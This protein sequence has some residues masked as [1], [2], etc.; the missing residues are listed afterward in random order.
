MKGRM[1]SRWVKV[2][3]TKIARMCTYGVPTFVEQMEFAGQVESE[4]P[5][6]S[7]RNCVNGLNMW[8]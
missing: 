6:A 7:E 5:Q 4:E 2:Y 8:S 3:E 1:C